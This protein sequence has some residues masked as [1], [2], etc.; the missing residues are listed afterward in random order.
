MNTTAAAEFVRVTISIIEPNGWDQA[1]DG[2]TA[3]GNLTAADL[4][5]DV[6]DAFQLAAED[7]GTPTFKWVKVVTRDG[8]T[9]TFNGTDGRA[10]GLRAWAEGVLA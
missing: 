5:L 10:S 9:H 2:D 8:V 3:H 7:G 1:Q 4:V 6:N